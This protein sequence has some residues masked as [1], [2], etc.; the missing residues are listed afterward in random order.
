MTNTG[1]VLGDST[2]HGVIYTAEPSNRYLSW[3]RNLVWA[4]TQRGTAIVGYAFAVVGGPVLGPIVGGAVTQSYLRW[5]C[6]SAFLKHASIASVFPFC[7]SF[8]PSHT[9]TNLPS[10]ILSFGTA[11][12]CHLLISSANIC[13][14]P[15]PWQTRH[16]SWLGGRQVTVVSLSQPRS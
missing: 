2:Y 9:I 4:P 7:S 13:P 5:R 6:K 3:W 8:I 11:S 15:C 1:G 10:V 12:N 14:K 16:H